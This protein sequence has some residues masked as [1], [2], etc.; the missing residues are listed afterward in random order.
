VCVCVCVY[1]LQPN[2]AMKNSKSGHSVE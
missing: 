2:I 1:E